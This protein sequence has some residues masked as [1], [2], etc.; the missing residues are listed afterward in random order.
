[1]KLDFKKFF[2]KNMKTTGLVIIF[3][4]GISLLLIPTSFSG[5]TKSEQK[6]SDTVQTIQYEAYEKHLEKRLSG[7][8]STVRGISDVSVMIT[9]ENSGEAYYAQNETSETKHAEDGIQTENIHSTSNTLALKSES[10]NRQMPVFL[11][12]GM[13][14]ISGVLVTAKGVDTPSA[15]SDIK[16]AVR[17]VLNVSVHRIQVLPKA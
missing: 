3:I 10:G 13:P 4:I 8:L 15:Q 17:A 1:M 5:N 2:E 14:E 16:S 11:K 7:I 9:L 12:S 6:E